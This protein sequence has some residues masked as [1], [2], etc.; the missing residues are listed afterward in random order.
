MPSDQLGQPKLRVIHGDAS[1]E[2]I[3]AILAVLAVRRAMATAAAAGTSPAQA[4]SAW[5][6]RSRQLR[7]PL[8]H[9]PGN[10]RR[11]ALP[12]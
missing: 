12:C 6:D 7:A 1:P 8:F 3:A 4:R 2:E 10:W 9:S 5:S 11:A